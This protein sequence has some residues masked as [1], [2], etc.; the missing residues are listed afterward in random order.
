MT[1]PCLC[2]I[3]LPSPRI[4]HVSLG[5]SNLS[6]KSH[7]HRT[8]DCWPRLPLINQFEFG[9]DP[10]DVSWK[11]FVV[12]SRQFISWPGQQIVVFWCP[13]LQVR[14]YSNLW[15]RD[16]LFQR[17]VP[18]SRVHHH[19]YLMKIL[20]FR[21]H[22]EGNPL[23]TSPDRVDRLSYLGLEH[24]TK[25][26]DAGLARSRSWCFCCWLESRWRTSG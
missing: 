26:A 8:L 20:I 1:S 22:P 13:V 9:A 12:T 15:T 2:G 14:N 21:L 17:A 19:C 10:P 16:E 23:I 3:L 5:I 4:L 18:S 6:I 7:F 25:G 11:H 24:E